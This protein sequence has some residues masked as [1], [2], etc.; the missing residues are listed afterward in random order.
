MSEHKLRIPN[1]PKKKHFVSRE[2][3]KNVLAYDYKSID[4]S[5]IAPRLKTLWEGLVTVFPLWINPNVITIMGLLHMPIAYILTM[6]Y[7][8]NSITCYA[9]N[10]VFFGDCLLFVCLRNI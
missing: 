9:P 4:E 1:N 10:W 8:G 7:C 2:A 6:Y 3:E 5:I